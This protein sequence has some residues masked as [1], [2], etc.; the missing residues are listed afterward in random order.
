[1]KRN[2][3]DLFQSA[4]DAMLE[5]LIQHDHEKDF[6]DVEIVH[7][8]KRL[9]DELVELKNAYVIF[10]N[11]EYEY[12]RNKT[13]LNKSTYIISLCDLRHEFADCCNFPAMGIYMC[14]LL[15]REVG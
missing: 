8:I 13:E 2:Y 1:M 14:D 5:K 11:A 12:K 3:N 15:I 10:K 9:E 7:K 6:H 4:N